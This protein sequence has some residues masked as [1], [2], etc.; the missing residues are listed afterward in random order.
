MKFSLKLDYKKQKKSIP[1]KLPSIIQMATRT[2]TR[3]ASAQL[4]KEMLLDFTDVK[5]PKAPKSKALKP[6]IMIVDSP[7]VSPAPESKPKKS[8]KTSKAKVAVDADL[9]PVKE[10][11][12]RAPTAYN[13]FVKDNMTRVK[14]ENPEFTHRECMGLVAVL[15]QKQKPDD[16]PQTKPKKPRVPKEKKSD[17]GSS[18]GD[19]EKL[20]KKTRVPTAY[21]KHIGEAIKRLRADQPGLL[22]TDYMKMAVAEWKKQKDTTQTVEETEVK[23]QVAE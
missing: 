4:K 6:N 13:L 18:G 9:N 11:K 3:I 10:K 17:D 21:N 19:I 8:T 23:T 12:T 1:T 7:P 5:A 16:A 15:W 20:K 2:S 14:A 22:S